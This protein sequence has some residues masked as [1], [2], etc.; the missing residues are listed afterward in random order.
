MTRFLAAQE[1]AFLTGIPGDFLHK[2]FLHHEHLL[3]W[4]RTT[5][6]AIIKIFR[7]GIKNISVSHGLLGLKW[8]LEEALGRRHS[9]GLHSNPPPTSTSYNLGQD[10]QFA[11]LQKWENEKNERLGSLFS[12]VV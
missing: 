8:D 7:C 1:S 5:S 3:Y 10:K 9:T 2:N 11:H 12:S 4:A 6:E